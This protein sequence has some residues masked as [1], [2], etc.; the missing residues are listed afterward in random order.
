MEL[1]K[2]VRFLI[3]SKV[4][5]SMKKVLDDIQKSKGAKFANEWMEEAKKWL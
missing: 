3:D 2:V 1:I 5:E 4:K